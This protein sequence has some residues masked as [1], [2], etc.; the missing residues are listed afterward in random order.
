MW[1][2]ELKKG[3]YEDLQIAEIS[4]DAFSVCTVN[5]QLGYPHKLVAENS[6]SGGNSEPGWEDFLRDNSQKLHRLPLKDESTLLS[7]RQLVDHLKL[8][9]EHL[10][11]LRQSLF[12]ADPTGFATSISCLQDIIDYEAGSDVGSEDSAMGGEETDVLVHAVSQTTFMN[13]CTTGTI[14]TNANLWLPSNPVLAEVLWAHN[15]A[16]EQVERKLMSPASEQ[17]DGQDD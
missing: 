1:Y 4:A 10:P 6:G 8:H 13:A 7:W 3:S 11:V 15:V 9:S 16:N 17:T 2:L 14:D 12:E 5:D